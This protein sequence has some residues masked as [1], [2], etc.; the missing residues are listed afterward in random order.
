MKK[1][2][3]LCICSV[4]LS[5][6]ASWLEPETTNQAPV[7]S[8][9][10]MAQ[11]TTMHYYVQRLTSQLLNTAG[12]IDLR[13]SVAV[14]TILPIDLQSGQS[15]P[16]LGQQIQESLIT[17]STQAGLRVLEYKTMPAIKMHQDQDVMLSRDVTAL[18]QTIN[19]EYFLTGTYSE[20]ENSV[21]VN[22]RLISLADNTVVA[23]ASDY[24]PANAMWSDT[25]VSMKNSQIYRGSN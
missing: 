21:L 23:A 17:L 6:C 14:G 4:L 18:K 10:N 11:P 19:P 2:I 16:G 13:K 15:L 5:A 3:I 9:T 25:K 20:L 1:C 24:I 12:V 8:R 7:A 22:L